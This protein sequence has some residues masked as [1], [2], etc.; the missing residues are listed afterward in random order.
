MVVVKGM[1]RADKGDHGERSAFVIFLL[2][3]V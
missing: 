3:A 1:V 2:P